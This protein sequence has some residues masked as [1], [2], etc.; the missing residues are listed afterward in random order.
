[1]WMTASSLRPSSQANRSSGGT[2]S[3]SWRFARLRHLPCEPR[4]S[5]TTTSLRPASLRLATMF[6]P[7]NPA[8]PVT[9][10]IPIRRA[11][12]F[13]PSFARDRPPVQLAA[14]PAV[15]D[16]QAWDPPARAG[17]DLAGGLTAYRQASNWASTGKN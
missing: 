6:D 2:T 17:Q 14:I 1:M 9:N 3:A 5:L 12:I 16:G 10:S 11:G 13:R 15:N 8:P 4:T 7:M